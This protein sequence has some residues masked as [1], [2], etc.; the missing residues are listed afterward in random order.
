ME[1]FRLRSLNVFHLSELAHSIDLS[2]LVRVV[3][4]IEIDISVVS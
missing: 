2:K 4:R 3:Y 1:A